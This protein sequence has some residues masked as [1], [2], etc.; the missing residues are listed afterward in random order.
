[1]ESLSFSDGDDG[2]D[3][4]PSSSQ[5]TS[6]HNGGI[7]HQT[8]SSSSFLFQKQQQQ[9]QQQHLYFNTGIQLDDLLDST[10]YPP[11]Y[12]TQVTVTGMSKKVRLKRNENELIGKEVF[13]NGHHVA[14][15]RVGEQKVFATSL[16]C[17]HQK[18]SLIYGD[19]IIEDVEDLYEK[20]IL[21]CPTHNWKFLLSSLLPQHHEE[22]EEE[23]IA[24][25]E[26][27]NNQ[28]KAPC[29]TNHES[30]YGLEKFPVQI[31]KSG[32]I[33]I[34]FSQFST[35]MFDPPQF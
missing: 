26:E 30:H 34:G 7:A 32:E 25:G 12:K 28:K 15:F 6:N 17:P 13:V 22:E 5:E 31:S 27:K 21:T 3:G 2:V 29:L 1:M 20:V 14:L 18:S 11:K 4:A 19:V 23:D 9:Q 33:I 24:A 35:S 8:S 16:L 10:V